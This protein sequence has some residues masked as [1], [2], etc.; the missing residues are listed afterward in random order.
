MPN[1]PQPPDIE[2]SADYDVS[3][4]KVPDSVNE[5]NALENS[6]E[7]RRALNDAWGKTRQA[8]VSGQHREDA[9]TVERNGKVSNRQTSTKAQGEG[10]AE[11]SQNFDD[12]STALVHTHPTGDT[13]SP[14]PSAADIA[15]AKKAGRPVIVAS[16]EG[17]YEIAPGTGTVTQVSTDTSFKPKPL[18]QF[19][20]ASYAMATNKPKKS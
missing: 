14:R 16:R 10:G 15:A 20:N 4:A 19:K 6:T 5:D 2:S 8:S 3:S 11:M 12:D 18:G 9:F 13:T 1:K 17:L 7:F